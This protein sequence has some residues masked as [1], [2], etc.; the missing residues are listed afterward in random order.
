ME[1]KFFIATV[2]DQVQGNHIAWSRT[3]ETADT[4]EEAKEKA[5]AVWVDMVDALKARPDYG[6]G[7]IMGES[8]IIHDGEEIVS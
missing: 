3:V 6:N 1:K 4:L 8:V 7:A 2:S 5:Q